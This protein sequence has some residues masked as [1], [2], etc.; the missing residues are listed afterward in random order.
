MRVRRAWGVALTG[1]AAACASAGPS[2]TPEATVAS[3]EADRDLDP[4]RLQCAAASLAA[5][6][7]EA[8]PMALSGPANARAVSRLSLHAEAVQRNMAAQ[9]R[10]G[11]LIDQA[12]SEQRAVDLALQKGETHGVDRDLA[13]VFAWMKQAE[14]LR[15]GAENGPDGELTK[16]SPG[17]RITQTDLQDLGRYALLRARQSASPQGDDVALQEIL[18]IEAERPYLVPRYVGLLL[19]EYDRVDATCR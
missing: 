18:R 11:R 15:L 19:T 6:V 12:A 7:A 13:Q 1:L 14:G 5:Q 16:A 3:A 9:E 2:T 4:A 17:R 10:S 8:G